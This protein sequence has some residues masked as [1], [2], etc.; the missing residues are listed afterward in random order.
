MGQKSIHRHLFL[1]YEQRGKRDGEEKKRKNVM[2]KCHTT[3]SELSD[4]M[5]FYSLSRPGETSLRKHSPQ[6]PEPKASVGAFLPPAP[7]S[8]FSLLWERGWEEADVM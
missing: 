7:P 3:A 2:K 1:L 6:N 5:I 4:G 8:S